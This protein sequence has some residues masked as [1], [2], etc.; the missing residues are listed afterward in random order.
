MSAP[1]SRYSGVAVLADEQ[2]R[3]YLAERE[4]FTFQP[5]SDNRVHAV[6]EGDTLF[7]IAGRYFA[8]LPRACGLWWIIADFQPAPILDPTVTLD[9][10]SLV[11]PSVRAVTDVILPAIQRG[12]R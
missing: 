5:F 8:P 10:R 3:A 9:R 12:A 11:V 6:V 7:H 2:A 1:F 4:P